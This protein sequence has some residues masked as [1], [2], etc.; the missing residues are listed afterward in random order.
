MEVNDFQR[1]VVV[2]AGYFDDPVL[3]EF[4]D[5]LVINS[6]QPKVDLGVVLFHFYSEAI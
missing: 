2:E 5:I 6:A 3:V 1:G 4:E